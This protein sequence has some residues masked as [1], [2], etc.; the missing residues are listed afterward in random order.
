M[1]KL[2]YVL[3]YYLHP[4]MSTAVTSIRQIAEVLKVNERKV[5]GW[6]RNHPDYV[7]PRGYFKIMRLSLIQDK[8][9]KNGDT[10][11]FIKEG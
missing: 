2:V 5:G 8:R 6:L 7:N 4:D 10:K 9:S 11:N 1:S 3:D